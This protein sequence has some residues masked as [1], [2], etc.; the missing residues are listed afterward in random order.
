MAK[1]IINLPARSQAPRVTNTTA[2]QNVNQM[3][4]RLWESVEMLSNHFWHL[5]LLRIDG[6]V[7]GK[8]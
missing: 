4:F 3:L 1:S 5:F 7:K 8:T 6:E 2:S